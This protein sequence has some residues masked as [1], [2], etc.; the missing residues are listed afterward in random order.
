MTDEEIFDIAEQYGWFDDF[1]RWNFSDDNLLKFALA[2]E[3]LIKE[4]NS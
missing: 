2:I 4:K 3:K 1:G